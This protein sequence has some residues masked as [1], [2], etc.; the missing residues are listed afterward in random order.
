MNEKNVENFCQL[1][2]ERTRAND[3]IPKLAPRVKPDNFFTSF[4]LISLKSQHKPILWSCEESMKSNDPATFLLH[5]QFS[6]NQSFSP[7][8]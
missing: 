4:L 7:P 2:I 1:N 8:M 5:Q 6:R 3:F